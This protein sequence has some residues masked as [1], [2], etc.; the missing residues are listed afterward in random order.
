MK[1]GAL[2]SKSFAFAIR[3]VNLHRFLCG[4]QREFTLSKQILRS[5]TAIGAL[6]RE[7]QHAESKADFVH[8][9]AIALKEANETDYWLA[10]LRETNYLDA[11]AACSMQADNE[12]LLRLLV[13]IIKSTKQN[14]DRR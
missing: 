13:S 2:V 5:G 10:L 6:V 11:D 1:D 3:V 7:A 4:E 9:L 12:E 14:S 8:K